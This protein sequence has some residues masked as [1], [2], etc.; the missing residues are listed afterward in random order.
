M[1]TRSPVTKVLRRIPL[2]Q[3]SFKKFDFEDGLNFKS[4]LNDEELMVH[5][6][7]Y[8]GYR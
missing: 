5:H 2:F 8:V 3:A 6:H 4:L 7:P 1:L